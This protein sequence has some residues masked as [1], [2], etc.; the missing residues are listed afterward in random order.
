VIGLDV[1]SIGA[2]KLV[3]PIKYL[4]TAAAVERPSAIAQTIKD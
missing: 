3:S 1:G 4:S 2:G